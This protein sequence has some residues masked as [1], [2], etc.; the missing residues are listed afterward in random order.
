MKTGKKH[1][2]EKYKCETEV[3]GLNG[4]KNGKYI[5]EFV[6]KEL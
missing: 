6:Q 3:I 4:R 1:F 5:W 2:A